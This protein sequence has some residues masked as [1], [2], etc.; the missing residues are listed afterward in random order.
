MLTEASSFGARPRTQERPPCIQRLWMDCAGGSAGLWPL[1]IPTPY[2]LLNGHSSAGGHRQSMVNLGA[3]QLSLASPKCHTLHGTTEL[4]RAR[5]RAIRYGEDSELKSSTTPQKADDIEG[6]TVNVVVCCY[7]H[8]C[9]LVADD[10]AS[11]V[12]LEK[13][14]VLQDYEVRAKRETYRGP[15]GYMLFGEAERAR[16]KAEH[17]AGELIG[18]ISN[19]VALRCSIDQ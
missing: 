19:A 6:A 16:Y 12:V 4:K 3:L 2:V 15:S 9:A 7:A 10:P 11:K 14:P 13:L 1:G 5:T 8:T 17:K 18:H